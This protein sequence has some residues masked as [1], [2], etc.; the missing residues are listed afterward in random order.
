MAKQCHL[1]RSNKLVAISQN[2]EFD[3]EVGVAIPR[4]PRSL[5]KT[6]QRGGKIVHAWAVRA[7]F[8]ANELKSSRFEMEWPHKSGTLQS[9][10]EVDRGAWFVAAEGCCRIISAQVEFI[11]RLE[12][13]VLRGG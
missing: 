10:P 7:D 6:R 5:G 2:R 8:D 12:A 11:R 1:R 4:E 9:F 13:E 3:E